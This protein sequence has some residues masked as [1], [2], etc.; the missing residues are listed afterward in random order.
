MFVCPTLT[1]MLY[2]KRATKRLLEEKEGE[3]IR[4]GFTTAEKLKTQSMTGKIWEEVRAPE[5]NNQ[6]EEDGED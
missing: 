6:D 1:D 4:L 2:C 5:D 3:D